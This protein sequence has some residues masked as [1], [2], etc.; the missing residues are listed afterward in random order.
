MQLVAA[1]GP[2][3]GIAP[4]PETVGS[5]RRGGAFGAER[6]AA[7][8]ADRPERVGVV[9]GRKREV[10]RDRP[11]GVDLE[12]LERRDGAKRDHDVAHHGDPDPAGDHLAVR[13]PVAGVLKSVLEIGVHADDLVG[14]G[15]HPPGRR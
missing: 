3:V 14:E 8:L 10:E 13:H 2:A 1:T 15:V 6:V 7:G 4:R 12:F 5:F 11:A 9:G